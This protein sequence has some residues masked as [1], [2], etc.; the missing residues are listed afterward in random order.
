MVPGVFVSKRECHA[1]RCRGVRN[2]LRSVKTHG[3]R[4]RSRR[5]AP[6]NRRHGRHALENKAR[7]H[8]DGIIGPCG[9]RAQLPT[10]MSTMPCRRNNRTADIRIDI[11]LRLSNGQK[12]TT[13]MLSKAR[14]HPTSWE[15]V[16]VGGR[17]QAEAAQQ[18][19]HDRFGAL[20]STF[21]RP[22]ARL[23]PSHL[24]ACLPSVPKSR[25]PT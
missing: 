12:G 16:V 22:R 2:G 8:V 3:D 5:S 24:H 18:D 15:R 21:H 7:A 4:V 10:L 14:S 6:P 1:P 9:F 13:L 19:W 11:G 17:S 25:M 23:R 20:I